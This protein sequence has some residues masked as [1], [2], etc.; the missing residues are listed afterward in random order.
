MTNTK[1]YRETKAALAGKSEQELASMLADLGAKAAGQ[2]ERASR[3][4]MQRYFAVED[5]LKAGWGR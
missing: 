2:S 3:T 5:T 4:T 1:A